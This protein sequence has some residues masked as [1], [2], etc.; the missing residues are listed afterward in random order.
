MN[1]GTEINAWLS[2]IALVFNTGIST[3]LHRGPYLQSASPK[4]MV[5]RW[6]TNS[7]VVGILDYGTTLSSLNFSKADL[8][9]KKEH[10]L[11]LESLKPNTKY[12]YNIYGLDDKGEKFFLSGDDQKQYF[13]TPPL[14]GSEDKTRIWVLGDP[15]VISHKKLP[16]D[17]HRMQYQ[18][19]DAY[20]KYND[21]HTDMVLMLGDNAYP[22]GRDEEYQESIF[23]FYD[24]IFRQSVVW[25]TF[26]NHDS[27]YDWKTKTYSAVSYPKPSGVYYD[28]FTLPTKGE[29]GGIASESEAYYSF[30]HANIHFLSLDSTDSIWVPGSAR[31]LWSPE[32]KTKN[33]M[34]EWLK[35]D[36]ANNKQDWIIAFWHHPPY[37]DNPNGS[38][39][40]ESA[41]WSR[42]Y[43]VPILEDHG[44]DFVI[45]GHNHRYQRSY[46]LDGHYGYSDSLDMQSMVKDSNSGKG[47]KAYRKKTYHKKPGKN[48]AHEG[49]VYVVAGSSGRISP[50]KKYPKFPA[51]YVAK[52]DIGSMIID[53][54]GN[55]LDAKFLDGRGKVFDDFSIIKGN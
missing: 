18:V 9:A 42:K 46:L 50:S 51:M 22:A 48:G 1:F 47:K 17:Q 35:K 15:G 5:V 2:S 10:E 37:S 16:R 44:V 21:R 54:E 52:K 27:G 31:E 30:D 24:K 13:I 25:P 41:I 53:V 26:G 12:F 43:L 49:T 55:R 7:K 28:I 39:K 8:K 40:N 32:S 23:E 6:R 3:E 20:Y 34:I 29:S 38:D 45:A 14:K 19:R 11:K 33:P 36:L 4:S